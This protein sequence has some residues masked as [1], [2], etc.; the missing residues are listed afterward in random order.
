MKKILIVIL[1]VNVCVFTCFGQAKLIDVETR[2][3]K[4]A[5]KLKIKINKKTKIKIIFL[6]LFLNIVNLLII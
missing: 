4:T 6:D 1:I 5:N 3:F 2:K